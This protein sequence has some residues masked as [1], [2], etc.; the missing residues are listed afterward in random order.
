MAA[1]VG[2]DAAHDA[3]ELR[4]SVGVDW[5]PI[6]VETGEQEVDTPATQRAVHG[7][8]PEGCATADAHLVVLEKTRAAEA[9]AVA[10]R[11]VH[12]ECG[13]AQTYRTLSVCLVVARGYTS[14]RLLLTNTRDS[15]EIVWMNRSASVV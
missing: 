4:A 14:G 7:P 2:A 9:V 13:F 11:R 6:G 1:I 5:R 15:G 12:W 8:E 3:S 10:A